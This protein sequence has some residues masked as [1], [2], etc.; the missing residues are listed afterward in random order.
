MAGVPAGRGLPPPAAWSPHPA[1]GGGGAGKLTLER[2]PWTSDALASACARCRQ[3]WVPA[4][5]PPD[6]RLSGELCAVIWARGPCASP[7][8]GFPSRAGAW[9]GRLPAVPLWSFTVVVAAC[10][11]PLPCV[12]CVAWIGELGPGGEPL[13][14]FDLRNLDL[15]GRPTLAVCKPSNQKIQHVDLCGTNSGR[16]ASAQL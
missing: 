15:T 16:P 13:G 3:T 6:C 9:R 1:R 7:F 12:W 2:G 14:R 11:R 4:G 5:Q 8:P 10:F